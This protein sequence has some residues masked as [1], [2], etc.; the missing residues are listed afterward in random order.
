MSQFIRRNHKPEKVFI[1]LYGTLKRPQHVFLMWLTKQQYLQ[2]NGNLI[3]PGDGAI[4]LSSFKSNILLQKTVFQAAIVIHP[5]VYV[6]PKWTYNKES[7]GKPEILVVPIVGPWFEDSGL[8]NSEI[9]FRIYNK[10]GNF[11]SGLYLPGGYNWSNSAEQKRALA[12]YCELLK[13]PNAI[14]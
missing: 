7:G 4:I 1:N 11:R 9:F 10:K 3:K 6:G 14:W 2:R 12:L 8:N 13:H 5:P